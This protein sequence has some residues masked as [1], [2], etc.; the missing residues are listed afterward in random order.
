M[1]VR[2]RLS[3]GFGIVIALM[4]ALVVV[5]LVRLTNIGEAN[6]KIVQEDWGKSNSAQAI[7]VT[8]RANVELAMELFLLDDGAKGKATD[9]RRLIDG[10]QKLIQAELAALQALI[11]LPKE[12]ELMAKINSSRSVYEK[13]ADTIASLLAA[14]RWQEAART[15]LDETLPSLGALQRNISEM[16]KLQKDLGTQ[17]GTEAASNIDSARRM[18]TSMGIAALLIGICFAYVITKS[19][20]Q[21]LLTAVRVAESVASGDLTSRIE[22]VGRD[23]TAQ[24]LRSI[25]EMNENLKDIVGRIRRGTDTIADAS[26]QIAT[27]GL[28]LSAR[29]EEQASSLEETV[30]SMQEL[31]SM[32]KQNADNAQHA[33]SLASS[34]SDI[35]TKGG[36]AIKQVIDVMAAITSSARQISDITAVIDGI[37]F[38]T[39]ILALNAAV[40]AARAGENGRGF[41][42]VASEVRNLAQRS[43]TA[44]KE[45]KTLIGQSVG[46]VESG[47]DLV[48][49]AGVTMDEILQ[50]V[51]HVA[52]IMVEISAA[53]AAQ[54]AGIEQVNQA[55]NQMEKVTQQNASLVEETTAASEAL[56]D[57][58]RG[59]AELIGTFR[60][61]DLSSSTP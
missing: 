5:G 49:Q 48:G 58:T 37:A 9:I 20:T 16:V 8:T 7:D 60:L 31:T 55:I 27:G 30:A 33:N 44:A 61:E 18:M 1:K 53:S 38:Q 14:E 39:N 2:A 22:V 41:A 57:Q 21:P 6:T 10:N 50:S 32:V 35:A 47:S 15:M 25:R 12:T 4:I 56:R 36:A 29:T 13:S 11:R 19:I 3:L 46:K 34:A 17:H 43:A 59:L 23:E 52:D 54:S 24:M 51:R 28:D 40:E 45:I 42:V 26:T